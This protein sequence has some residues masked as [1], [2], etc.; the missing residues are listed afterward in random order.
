MKLDPAEVLRQAA[1]YA[2]QQIDRVLASLARDVE[3]TSKARQAL[4]PGS[5]RAKV[6]TANAR[7]ARA[8]EARA[9]LERLRS[10]LVEAQR[11]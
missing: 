4:P 5:S 9:R 8:C 10:D 7:W 3:R 2:L 11:G 6:T 1:P